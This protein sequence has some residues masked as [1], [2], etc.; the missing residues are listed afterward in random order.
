MEQGFLLDGI[1]AKPARPSI[2]GQ[3]NLVLLAGPDEAEPLLTFL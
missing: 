1:D 3:D 2:G